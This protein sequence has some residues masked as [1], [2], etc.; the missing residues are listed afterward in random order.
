MR[1][2]RVVTVLACAAAMLA[3]LG[4]PARAAVRPAAYY[5]VPIYIDSGPNTGNHVIDIANWG[6]ANRSP[7]QIWNL[8]FDEPVWNQRWQV[9]AIGSV[10]DP[11]VVI[12]N[13]GSGK[14][15]DKSQDKPDANGNTVYLY[16]CSGTSNQQWRAHD[17]GHGSAEL[18]NLSDGRC[19]DARDVSYANG[20]PLQVWSC[21]GGWNQRWIFPINY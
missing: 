18:I 2:I 7:V 16:T 10:G 11:I 1:K 17:M 9:N 5:T 15:L 8:R 21:S 20:T 4:A 13:P 19:L 12:Y 14:C 6:T 3:G